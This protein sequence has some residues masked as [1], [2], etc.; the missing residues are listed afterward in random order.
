ML[1][2]WSKWCAKT[3]SNAEGELILPGREEYIELS[4]PKVA[5]EDSH[6]STSY[7]GEMQAHLTQELLRT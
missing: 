2:L 1:Y 6:F 3:A 4:S 5:I 7:V